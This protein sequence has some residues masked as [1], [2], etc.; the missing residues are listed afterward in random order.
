MYIIQLGL[1]KLQNFFK[2]IYKSRSLFLA[3]L[4]ILSTISPVVAAKVSSP[5][6]IVQSR[7]DAEQLANKATTLY[8]NGKFEEAATAWKQTATAF[9]A[10]GDKLNQAMAFSNLSL[11][12]Q[13]LGQWE[14]AK[15]TIEDSLEILKNQPQG[16]EQFKIQAQSLDVQGYLQ[17]ELGQSAD[18]L[19]SWE[20]ATKIYSQI[21]QPEKLAQSKINQAQ[22]M[23][24]LGLYPRACNTLLEVVSKELGVKNCQ[25]LDPEQLTLEEQEKLVK[26]LEEIAKQEYPLPTVVGLRSLGELL[27]V[28]GQLELAT[29]IL[30]TSIN[31]AQ[32][33]NSP[34]DQ[35]VAYLSLGNTLRDIAQGKQ[36]NDEAIGEIED[37]QGRAINS[38][39]D[40]VKLSPSPTTQQ[41]AQVNKLSLLLKREEFQQA[42]EL[43]RT[44]KPQLSNLSPS[45]AGVYLQI[46]LAH[47]FVELAKQGILT[48]A[49]SQLPTFEEIDQILVRATEQ[50]KSLGDKRA[51]A[52]ALGNR[53]SLYLTGTTKNLSQAEE[54]TRQSL[55]IASSL[56]APDIAYQFARQ[57]G[58][59][60]KEQGDIQDSITAY[61]TSYDAL[62]ALRRDLIA[63]NPEV[64]F[65]F[66]NT[67]EPVYRE[68]VELDLEYANSLKDAGKN[69]ESQKLL[70]QARNVLESLQVAELNNFFREACVEENPKQID[71]IDKAAAVVYTIVLPNR[72]E[73]ILSLPEQPNLSLHTIKVDQKEFDDTID[74]VQRS[75][76]DP[77]SIEEASRTYYKKLYDWVIK[78]LEPELKNSKVTTLAF[79]L[80]GEL[81]NI[82]MGILYDGNQYLVQK[83]A[84]ALTPGLQLLDPKPIAKVNLRAFTAGLSKIRPNFE[85]HRDF[86]PLSNVQRE[87]EQIEKIGLS[88][89]LI[90]NEKFTSDDLQQE[91][92]A[93]RV[94]PIVHLATHG[95]FSST[96]DRTF[97]L[98]WDR[99]INV[100][101]LGKLLQDKT[102][103]QSRPIELLVLSAC[104]TA[105]G[106]K[107]AAL[108]LAGV[109]VRAGARST[110]ATLWSVVDET[111]AEIMSEFYNQLKDAQ[112]T[113]I[114]K[115]Q[116]LQKA[117]LAFIDNYKNKDYR[118]PHFWAPFVLVGNWQ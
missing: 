95:E 32:K 97:I 118:H 54:F 93:S 112:K 87:L 76:I 92:R 81:R 18:A 25:E 5:T 86:L 103:Y 59:I 30:Q 55:F 84:I 79:V 37:Y 71:K 117:Q 73:V 107:R 53:G 49:N 105:S 63:L 43:W 80:D 66:Q 106:D 104:K 108:G 3:A 10:K 69:E 11:T 74:E 100:K 60:R 70:V 47:S 34:Q 19:K 51:E 62:Q 57:L 15:K 82:P 116:A 6:P 8:R 50:A 44:L 72:L 23:Q 33:L 28:Q 85:P 89:Q 12:Y 58:Q 29:A 114:N 88:N 21:N 4:F 46:N 83:Y 24:D 113:N 14:Q 9:A 48:K 110:L 7:F 13:Q 27:R 39:D 38:Y 2:R 41:Q 99:R 20:E 26:R 90:L 94:P 67:V 115:A 96:A 111:T 77:V 78:P 68:L 16:K 40:V 35:A 31:L 22:A 61:T 36:A 75:L 102:L 45:R 101:Q 91:I 17:R 109:A 64:Q 98:S 1:R 56:K 52:H 42:E 65:S